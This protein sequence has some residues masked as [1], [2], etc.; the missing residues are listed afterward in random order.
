MHTPTG[1]SSLAQLSSAR[2]APNRDSYL[3]HNLLSVDLGHDFAGQD[4]SGQTLDDK[5]ALAPA[6]ESDA[7][8]LHTR[9]VQ[10]RVGRR[11]GEAFGRVAACD[12]EEERERSDRQRGWDV[13]GK[14]AADLVGEQH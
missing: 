4:S 1:P 5:T 2:G 11:D 6:A 14:R 9:G 12:V 13:E 10:G 8:S 7:T 3:D